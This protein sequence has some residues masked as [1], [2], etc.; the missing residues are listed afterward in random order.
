MTQRI[1]VKREGT[2]AW[3]LFNN[4]QHHNAVSLDMWLALPELLAELSADPEVKVVALAGA[5]SKAF[6]SGADIS[7]FNSERDKAEGAARY[8]AATNLAFDALAAMEKPT[9]AMIRGYCLGGGIGIALLCDIRIAGA[10]ARFS[11]PAAKLGLGYQYNGIRKL[12]Q[13]IGSS[14][15]KEVIFTGR[16]FDAAEALA[17]GLVNR[18]VAADELAGYTEKY[19]RMIGSNAPLTIR[20][21]KLAVA[22]AGLDESQRDVATVQAAIERCF[23]SEDYAEGRQAFMEKRPPLFN[24]R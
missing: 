17:M 23:D 20:A 2:A 13:T 14:F 7:E 16:Q 11:V 4:P 9:I 6:I 24:G 3:I 5:G 22:A 21:A 19:I 1:I 12:V 10:D 18:V 8:E 15:A